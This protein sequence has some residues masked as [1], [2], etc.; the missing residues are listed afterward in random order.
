MFTDYSYEISGSD[1]TIKGTVRVE[2]LP[3]E[4]QGGIW[5][6][7]MG[8]IAES[9]QIVD[10]KNQVVGTVEL[11]TDEQRAHWGAA[12]LRACWDDIEEACVE[13][14]RRELAAA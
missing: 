12:V 9:G 14:A 5:A 11:L 10:D 13:A 6:E 8:A 7:D 1:V 2:F 4:W 3:R